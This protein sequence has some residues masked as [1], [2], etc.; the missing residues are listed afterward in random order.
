MTLTFN[1]MKTTV[2]IH[3]RAKGRGQSLLGSK[4]RVETDG[5][6]DRRRR[7]DYFTC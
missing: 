5:R 3:T 1:A 7:L 6:T 2:M 4:V